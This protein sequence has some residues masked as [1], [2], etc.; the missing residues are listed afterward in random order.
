V[1]DGDFGVEVTVALQQPSSCAAIWF[2]WNGTAG[3]QMLRACETGITISND[4]P[5]DSEVIGTF[6]QARSIALRTRTR[7]H[8]VVRGH[9][10]T[11]WQ[12]DRMAGT[13]PLP[14]TGPAGGQVL[15]GIGVE[16]GDDN[17]PYS[18]TF[19]DVDIRSF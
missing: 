10:A 16:N 7:I 18:V 14:E 4:Q 11:L 3:G 5:G 6:G 17:P 9:L 8:L 13:V 2:H 15:L 1:L 12:D 19:S